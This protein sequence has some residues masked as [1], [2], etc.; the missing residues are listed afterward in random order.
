M[1]YTFPVNHPAHPTVVAKKA[2]WRTALNWALVVLWAGM[3]WFFS[4][5]PDLKSGL[6]QDFVLRKVAHLLEFGM[7]TV[8]LYRALPQPKHQHWQRFVLAVLIALAYAAI[9]EI[10]QGYV[11]GREPSVRDVGID[12]IGIAL[13]SL[14]MWLTQ[15]FA[16][17]RRH[18]S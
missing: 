2:H 14:V 15:R 1:R 12:G 6:D 5:I 9:D 11:P 3:M 4:S 16:L 17:K 18:A 10:H 13:G 7:L 8:L